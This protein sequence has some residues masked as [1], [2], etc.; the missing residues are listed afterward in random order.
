MVP[1]LSFVLP[2]SFNTSNTRSRP[3]ELCSFLLF[4]RAEYFS[5]H[6]M[7]HLSVDSQIT[8][9]FFFVRLI[10]KLCY[11]TFQSL[12]VHWLLNV[13]WHM[14]SICG[15]VPSPP[16][17]P[18]DCD[19]PLNVFMAVAILHQAQ[20]LFCLFHGERLDSLLNILKC[21]QHIEVH[22]YI[23]WAPIYGFH[24]IL[25]WSGM[26]SSWQPSVHSDVVSWSFDVGSLSPL[27]RSH[28]GIL[29]MVVCAETCCK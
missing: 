9:A 28:V 17:W 6:L 19:W 16:P 11:W 22:M 25:A 8:P 3:G 26:T 21:H 24:G 5:C 1:V 2:C 18:T 4:E 15:F 14:S 12:E 10:R 13:P 7:R 29:K 27:H 23:S 20:M